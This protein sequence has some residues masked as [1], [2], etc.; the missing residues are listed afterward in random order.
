MVTA[1][2]P[3]EFNGRSPFDGIRIRWAGLALVCF[4]VGLPFTAEPAGIVFGVLFLALGVA[5]WLL[6]SF[7]ARWWYDI[8]TPQRYIVGTGAII[9]TLTFIVFVGGF[10]VIA[11]LIT[12]FANSS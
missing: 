12:I 10:L 2:L 7:G 9:G 5:T 4:G 3:L 11:W 1:R 8:P 6:S